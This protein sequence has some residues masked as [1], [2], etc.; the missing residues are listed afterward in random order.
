MTDE[1]AVRDNAGEIQGED[2]Q[3]WSEQE[4]AD[5]SRKAAARG[6]RP[7]D[8]GARLLRRVLQLEPAGVGWRSL[9]LLLPHG[10]PGHRRHG[11]REGV[12]VRLARGPLPVARQPGPAAPVPDA[13]EVRQVRAVRGGHP[14][15]AARRTAACAALYQVQGQ[16]GR[17]QAALTG[18]CSGE[19][20]PRSSSR[21]SPPSWP[22]RRGS[23]P[24][25]Q[26]SWSATTI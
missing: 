4:A 24:R 1:R 14:V 19:R 3:G 6:A 21:T 10:G 22:R 18:A 25:G 15:R 16:G 26:F 23:P 13:G 8:E 5:P 12:P 20:P 2:D 17:W 9:E 11:A 7:R